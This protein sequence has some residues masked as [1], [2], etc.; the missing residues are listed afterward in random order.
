MHGSIVGSVVDGG[1]DG[2]FSIHSDEIVSILPG[3]VIATFGIIGIG[4]G[5]GVGVGVTVVGLL[6]DRLL[7]MVFSI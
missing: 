3:T 2:I 6:I 4:V 5:V 7:T 1:R